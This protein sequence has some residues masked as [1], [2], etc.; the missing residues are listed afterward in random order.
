MP[1]GS[2]ANM[3]VL[4]FS[5]SF[6]YQTSRKHRRVEYSGQARRFRIPLVPANAD[7]DLALRCRPRLKPKV[8]GCEVKLLVIQRIIR[9][10]H[11]AVFAEQFSIHV[12]DCRGVVIN[13]GAAFFE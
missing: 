10:M 8:D 3:S 11:L 1:A 6:A 2:T 7:A 9:D 12:N 5:L 13:A 4:R